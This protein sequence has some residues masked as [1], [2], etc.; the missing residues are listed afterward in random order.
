MRPLLE[1]LL[2]RENLDAAEAEALL[3]ELTDPSAPPAYTGA[4]LAALRTKGETAE[5]L[6]GLACGLDRLA[7]R[8]PFAGCRPLIDVVG[9]GG[10]DSGSLNLS[11]GT[12]LLVAAC[13]LAVAKHGNR[14]VSSRSGSADVLEALGVSLPRD[15]ADAAKSLDEFSFTFLHAPYFHPTMRRL[16]E[17]RRTIGVRTV[18]NLLGPI[19]NPARPSHA[20]I[21]ACD[22]VTAELLAG[23]L[24]RGSIERAWVVHGSPGWDEPTPCG[25]FLVFEVAGG[26]VQRTLR[27]PAEWGLPRRRPEELAGGDATE[28]ARSLARVFAGE[29]GAHRDALVLGAALVLELTGSAD[30]PGQA[31]EIVE[32]LIDR[33]AAANWLDRI[34]AASAREARHG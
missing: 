31:R 16:A 17:V 24:A 6:F 25:P 21:G 15:G 23:A 3:V 33:G 30:S 27:N 20:L 32:A 13:G 7:I 26:A 28:N 12:A 5:E 4:V 29:R 18:F 9:T 11:T 1:R 2:R 22:P 8:P 19:C 14:S 10:D 34:V